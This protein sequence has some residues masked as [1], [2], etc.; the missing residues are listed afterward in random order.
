[1]ETLTII[2]K[3]EK[4][5]TGKGNPQEDL[6][7]IINILKA[8]YLQKSHTKNRKDITIVKDFIKKIDHPG[9]KGSYMTDEAIPHYAICD[10]FRLLESIS[11]AS[12]SI[13]K[14]FYNK[15]ITFNLG[16]EK[17]ALNMNDL[18]EVD[19]NIQDVEKAINKNKLAKERNYPFIVHYGDNNVIGLNPSYLMD[20]L[21]IC[22]TNKVYIQTHASSKLVTEDG[23]EYNMCTSP[24]SII[25]EDYRGIILPIRLS[26]IQYGKG[27]E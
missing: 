14:E 1:M 21:Q 16:Y 23:E 2:N 26:A 20:F 10:G 4:V 8:D 15:E 13:L 3:L 11:E 7:E 9:M 22:K 18:M 17:T 25:G 27:V 6:L 19:I 5:R 24:I 12:E